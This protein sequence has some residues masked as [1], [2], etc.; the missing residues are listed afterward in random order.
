LKLCDPKTRTK[1]H[2]KHDWH[3]KTFFGE[4]TLQQSVGRRVA[5]LHSHIAENKGIIQLSFH[6]GKMLKA[7]VRQTERQKKRHT[8]LPYEKKN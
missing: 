7:P 4:H 2:H 3:S 6:D 5:Q 1:C 8:K